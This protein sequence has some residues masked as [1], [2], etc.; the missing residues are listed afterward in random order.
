MKNSTATNRKRTKNYYFTQKMF[1]PELFVG[2][3][4]FHAVTELRELQTSK[5]KS[6]NRKKTKEKKRYVIHLS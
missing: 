1:F 2:K 4:A 6:F 3:K 5:N